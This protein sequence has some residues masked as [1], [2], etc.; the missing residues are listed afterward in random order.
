MSTL[1]IPL[2]D[3]RLKQIQSLI[4]QGVADNKASLV[5]KAIDKFIEDQVIEAILKAQKEPRLSGDLDE[6]AARFK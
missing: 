5:R 2:S 1:S 3:D 4:D 6:L